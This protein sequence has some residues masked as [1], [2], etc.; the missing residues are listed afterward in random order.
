MRVIAYKPYNPRK[1]DRL[2]ALTRMSMIVL[3]DL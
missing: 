2:N 1:R 3:E